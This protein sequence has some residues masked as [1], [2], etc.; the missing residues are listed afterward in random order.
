MK[1]LS[2]WER[3]RSLSLLSL[4]KGGL[5]AVGEG[6]CP[7][8]RAEPLTQLRLANKFASLRNPLPKERGKEVRWA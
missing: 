5:G 8:E 6:P 7:V 3:I 4:S 1:T 2:L